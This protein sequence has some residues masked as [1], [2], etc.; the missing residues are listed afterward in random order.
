MKNTAEKFHK[1]VYQIPDR[2]KTEAETMR[3]KIW[4]R[5]EA[6]AVR[7]R[8][9]LDHVRRRQ[10][11]NCLEA[12]S[13]RGRCLEDSIPGGNDVKHQLSVLLWLWQ[14]LRRCLQLKTYHHHQWLP[15]TQ[16]FTGRMS[17]LSPYQQCQSTEG[18]YHISRTC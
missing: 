7:S 1:K 6:E 4:G 15:N 10:I 8:P 3:Q 2:A 12:A 5:A 9:K 17:F 14:T 18:K 16:L 11:K 13:S